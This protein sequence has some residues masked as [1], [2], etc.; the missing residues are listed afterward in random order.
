MEDQNNLIINKDNNQD[1]EIKIIEIVENNIVID[2][3]VP[4]N[5][6][7]KNNGINNNKKE[8][9]LNDKNNK[10]IN[11]N[12]NKEENVIIIN[13]VIDINKPNENDNMEEKKIKNDIIDKKEN[14][15]DIGLQEKLDMILKENKRK[16]SLMKLFKKDVDELKKQNKSITENFNAQIKELKEAQEKEINQIKQNYENKINE[17]KKDFAMKEDIKYFAKKREVEYVKDDL[18]A[19]NSKFSNLEREYNSKMG[20]MESNMERI[21]K[22]EDENKNNEDN[23]I[24][25]NQ[26][27]V[28]KNNK[29]VINNNKNNIVINNKNE[30]NKNIIPDY[31]DIKRIEAMKKDIET[32][33]DMKKYKEL[34]TILGEIF[35][36][37]NLKTKDIDKKSLEKLKNIN[38]KLVKE[39][40]F[41]LNF[42]SD[43]INETKLKLSIYNI[44][45]EHKKNEIY[46]VINGVNDE[47]YPKLNNVEKEK[48]KKKVDIKK[49]NIEAFRKEYNLSEEEFPDELLKDAYIKSGGNLAK[50]FYKIVS[51]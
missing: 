27:E 46:T 21:F 13:E 5:N 24:I 39:K 37:K 9:E 42:I 2:E 29:V 41:P 34:N 18:E 17:M 43:F 44:N 3:K 16:D 6:L 32:K 19:L 50:T 47:I 4:E 8:N 1:E 20:F 28:N 12:D 14:K 38:I 51:K 48:D 11:N 45:I 33:Y 31:F 35:S 10:E 40:F 26:N 15:D 25:I 7:E 22:I 30:I 49:F 36:E 23:K